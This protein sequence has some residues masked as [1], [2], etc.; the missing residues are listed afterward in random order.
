PGI[1]S[2]SSV[3]S[4]LIMTGLCVLMCSLG[5]ALKPRKRILAKLVHAADDKRLFSA[6]I[7]LSSIGLA[8]VLLLQSINIQIASNSNWTGPATVIYFFGNLRHVGFAVLLNLT[9]RKWN[10]LNLMGLAF[11]LMPVLYMVL[12][13][14]RR[15]STF[16]LFITIGLTLFYT[17]K[18]LPARWLVILAVAACA[19][20]I[21]L[22][23]ALRGDFWALLLSG[24]LS[25]IDFSSGID[26]ILLSGDVLELRNAAMSIET[27]NSTQSFGYGTGLWNDIVFQYVPGQLVGYEFKDS[28]MFDNA[29]PEDIKSLYGRSFS[30]GSTPTGMGDSYAE[31]GFAGCL[32]FGAI[33]YLFR[34][35]WV[36]STYYTSLYAQILYIAL[37]S[38]ALIGV[39]HGVGIFFQHAV[40]QSFCVWGVWKYSHIS[41][42]QLLYSPRLSSASVRPTLAEG[43]R[44]T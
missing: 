7:F 12:I 22:L 34:H 8:S 25:E 3:E 15:T 20:L 26:R 39:T 30:L 9:I 11:S 21:P 5:F 17:K 29:L 37:I 19:Y 38:P 35:I 4:V 24:Q 14:G 6:G 1:V 27:V 42:P 2:D 43:T 31:F 40:L 13:A 36:A 44:R 10:A 23:G 41:H 28:L 18:I 16:I 33:A 32:I